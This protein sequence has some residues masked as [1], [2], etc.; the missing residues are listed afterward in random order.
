RG[1]AFQGGLL[2]L[3]RRRR[4][5][6]QLLLLLRRQSGGDVVAP[7]VL[8][9]NGILL[10]DI[11]LLFGRRIGTGDVE[12]AVLHEV[13]IG[14]TAAGL[15]P[16]REFGVA[17]GESGGLLILGGRPLGRVSACLEIGRA[18]APPL[19]RRTNGLQHH[20]A[21]GPGDEKRGG[22]HC[23]H[24]RYS[25][26]NYARQLAR[27]IAILRRRTTL[28]KVRYSRPGCAL[29]LLPKRSGHRSFAGF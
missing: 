8:E 21:N 7:L 23:D 16:A 18:A 10:V 25:P 2:H 6:L 22:T 20:Q 14:I 24:R 13:V 5:R 11:F 27:I 3:L 12:G 4:R 1:V 9:I 29:F 17:L 28:V 15:A 19:R 26:A